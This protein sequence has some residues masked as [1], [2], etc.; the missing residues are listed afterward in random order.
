MSSYSRVLTRCMLISTAGMLL[1]VVIPDYPPMPLLPLLLPFIIG[2]APLIWYHVGY[3]QPRATDGL[4][5]AEVDSVYYYG[6]LVTV[7]ALGSTA[8][9]LSLN[10]VDGNFANVALQF[11]LG[12]LATGYAVWARV[13]L[14]AASGR[15]TEADI[16]EEMKKVVEKAR[17]LADNVDLASHRF[18]AL[19][20]QILTEQ[21]E[22]GQR[23]QVATETRIEEAIKVFRESAT[24]LAEEGKLAL[25][26]LRAVVNDVTFGAEREELRISVSGMSETVTA[27]S[28]SLT[29]L[30]GSA[31]L[32]AESVSEFTSDLG[33]LNA[34]AA[35]TYKTLA[36][37][38]DDRGIV[39]KLAEAIEAGRASVSDLQLAVGVASASIT[40]FSDS[41]SGAADP[42]MALKQQSGAAL[43]AIR[44][45]GEL[46]P[47]LT[48]LEVSVG[49]LDERI[50]RLG[51]S[52]DESAEALNLMSK[53]VAELKEVLTNL[54]AALIDS[55][56]GLKDSMLTISEEIEGR[57]STILSAADK[58]SREVTALR[59][60]PTQ[61]QV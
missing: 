44:Q 39:P 19:A 46:A 20:T 23:V 31:R 29:H 48:V 25:Q 15:L 37:L 49:S 35:Q 50:S 27:L 52:S 7:G 24:N 18:S 11:G 17:S 5:P 14:T 61:V 2:L 55:T 28:T 13:Q 57:L 59:F 45:I 51:I 33:E 40:S 10:G 58:K 30:N 12:L 16:L 22:F 1:G 38:G 6:F 53:N 32:G 34:A 36:A 54:N 41:A 9:R 60:D 47:R 4:G 42:L 3:L 43:A 56:G 8:L 21:Q 26:A